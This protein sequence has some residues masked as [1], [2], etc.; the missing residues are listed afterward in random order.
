MMLHGMS[1]QPELLCL[2][3]QPSIKADEQGEGGV[4]KLLLS[5]VPSAVEIRAVWTVLA[6]AHRT[7]T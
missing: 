1:A 7:S 2:Q 4:G 5:N 6:A 3:L